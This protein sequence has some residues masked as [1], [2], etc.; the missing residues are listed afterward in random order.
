MKTTSKQAQDLDRLVAKAGYRFVTDAAKA[1]AKAGRLSGTQKSKISYDDRARARLAEW[2]IEQDEEELEK[3]MEEE[4]RNGLPRDL[5]SLSRRAGYSFVS[6]AAK[7]AAKAGKLSGTQKS[8]I[9]YD[10]RAQERLIN[11]LIK[12]LS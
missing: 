4:E 7:A 8:K 1:C 11:W 3:Q 10:E 2:L 5:E 9:A 12:E 6:D